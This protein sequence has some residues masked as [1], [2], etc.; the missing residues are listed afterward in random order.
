MPDF[1]KYKNFPTDTCSICGQKIKI[2]GED[3]ATKMKVCQED[4]EH[5]GRAHLFLD[6]CIKKDCGIEHPRR[7]PGN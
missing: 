6:I 1:V 5:L 4:F 7:Q 3:Y 2:I